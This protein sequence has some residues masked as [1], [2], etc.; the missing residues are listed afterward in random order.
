MKSSQTSLNQD[1][2]QTLKPIRSKEQLAKKHDGSAHRKINPKEVSKPCQRI[3][4]QDEKQLPN[5]FHVGDIGGLP[6]ID[7]QGVTLSDLIKLSNKKHDIGC[8]DS[9]FL[10]GKTARKHIVPPFGRQQKSFSASKESQT[11]TVQTRMPANGRT[12]PKKV[13]KSCG[14]RVHD[15]YQPQN[16]VIVCDARRLPFFD[17][18]NL[19][20][21]QSRNENQLTNQQIPTR[22]TTRFPQGTRAKT[23]RYNAWGFRKR[24][25]DP[26]IV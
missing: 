11:N 25:V 7:T 26:H 13:P 18:P 20:L 10:K 21:N 24:P 22:T 15:E 4:N 6:L 8:T 12:C 17:I 23:R 2:K 1:G 19:P 5:T 14:I 3:Q 9:K 16:S